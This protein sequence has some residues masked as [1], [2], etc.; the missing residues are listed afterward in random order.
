MLRAMKSA[1]NQEAKSLD[2]SIKVFRDPDYIK[3][4]NIGIFLSMRHEVQ[5]RYIIE[6]SLE[7]K[8]RVFVPF[9]RKK[10]MVLMELI[11][12]QQYEKA[13][14]NVDK[15]GLPHLV[16]ET[17]ES[18]SLDVIFVPGVAFDKQNNRMGYGKGY[19][20]RFL[21]KYEERNGKTT[22]IGICFDYQIVQS[23]PVE[24]HDVA[25]SRVI[26]S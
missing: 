2:L 16:Q 4:K 7:Q 10:E 13:L 17:T 23:V 14:K 1:T 24:L 18:G 11:D 20:D 19:Y 21:R 8:K 25:L 22:T 15:Y 26:Y 9:I 5:T 12:K 3:A 6:D